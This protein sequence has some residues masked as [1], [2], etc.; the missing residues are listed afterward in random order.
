MTDNIIKKTLS[1]DIDGTLCE[2]T[3]GEYEK[4]APIEGRIKNINELYD[5]GHIINL[6]T[7]RGTTTGIDWSDI[8]SKQLQSWGVKYHSLTLGKPEADIYVDDKAINA[9]DFFKNNSENYFEEHINAVKKTFNSLFLKEI[10]DISI[11]IKNSIENKGKLILAGNGGSFSDCMH[12]SAELTGRFIKERR[13]LPSIVL[14]TNGSSISAISND[15]DF[16]ECFARELE[17]LGNKEDIFIAFSTSGSSINILKSLKVAKK[18][19]IFSVLIS[20]EKLNK[21]DAAELIIKAK[22]TK[23]PI[24]QEIHIIIAH[25]ICKQ[26]E[27][28]MGF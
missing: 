18:L 22:S 28:K 2:N 12:L 24:I 4:A 25:Y 14:G 8:T 20:S 16:S 1:V 3:F 11:K 6:Y 9:D 19:G 13:P 5:K 23:T 21:L 26:V 15:Y 17:A 7:A 10:E 27:S